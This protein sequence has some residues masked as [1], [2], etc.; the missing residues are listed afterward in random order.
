MSPNAQ[1]QEFTVSPYLQWGT[2]E[3]MWVL[4]ETSEGSESTVEW[5]ETNALGQ[6][7]Q[8]SAKTGLFSS[9][10]HTT[11]LDNLSPATR[12]YYRVITDEAVSPT[13]DFITAPDPASE[14]SFNLVAMSDMQRDNANPLV[15]EE[16]V[17]DGIINF[18][19]TEYNTD[20]A[21]ALDLVLIAGD[22]VDNGWLR[23]EW[24]DEFFAPSAPLMAHVPIYPVLGNHEANTSFYFDFFHLPDNGN[25]E[26]WWFLDYSNTRIIGLD[27][28]LLYRTQSQLDW[29]TTVLQDACENDTIDFVFAQLHHPYQ[30][31][32][33]VDGNTDYTGLV[34][35]LLES[36]TETCNKPSVHF[37]GHT[38]A[39]SRGQSRDHQHLWVNVASAGGNI[40]YWGE[41]TQMDYEQF[42]VSQDEWGFVVVEVEAG[43]DP[44]LRIRRVSRGNEIT[45]RDNEIRDEVSIYRSNQGPEQPEAQEPRGDELSPRC[46]TFVAS[47]YADPDFDLHGASHWQLSTDCASFEEP[48]HE[49][50]IQY[51]NWYGGEDLQAGDD[52]TDAVMGPIEGGGTYC[53]RVRYRDRSLAWGEWSDPL[54]FTTIA[55]TRSENLLENPGAEAGLDAWTITEGVVESLGEDECG[56]PAPIEGAHI[57]AAGGICDPTT[58][59]SA[60]QSID[61]SLWSEAIDGEGASVIYGGSLADYNG[62]DIPEIGLVFFDEA[63][64]S[65]GTAGP[66]THTTN[67]WTEV[68]EDLLIPASTRRVA[69]V[70]KG[71]RTNGVD[72]DS[73]LDALYLYV[74]ISPNG[75][76]DQG[77]SKTQ[78]TEPDCCGLPAKAGCACAARPSPRGAWGL[79]LLVLAPL[80]RRR[81]R[82]SAGL[83]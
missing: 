43:E 78:P 1:A 8:G 28:N 42:S 41:Y 17:E 14:A 33:W 13:Y 36:F 72:N 68:V 82:P 44:G 60:F 40:D 61:L 57:F 66:L 32:P 73:Y 31:E 27:S 79:A 30:S 63:G 22:L 23:D 7:T 45:P 52:L 34:I 16:L 74:D 19:T 2:P 29:L 49:A 64:A 71:T 76:C 11:K 10:I 26:H 37:F 55:G 62:S 25:N 20:L 81:R 4:W 5:G 18:V 65:L 3:S 70:M 67:V 39:Y 69:F 75:D 24:T 12:Y 56:A 51:E 80:L 15:Y 47:E 59:G 77:I 53:W 21:E 83:A 6:T 50:W 48:L 38:H 35:G 9:Q 54:A 58:I 46:T